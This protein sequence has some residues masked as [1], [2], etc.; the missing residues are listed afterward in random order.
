[1]GDSP[2]LVVRLLVGCQSANL[3]NNQSFMEQ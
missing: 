3:S 1:L 2:W